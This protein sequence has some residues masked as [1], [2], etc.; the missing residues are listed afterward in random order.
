MIS[1]FLSS[2]LFAQSE[3]TTLIPTRAT[4]YK[5]DTIPYITLKTAYVFSP[6][7]FKSKREQRRYTKL[8]RDIKKVYPYA[9][10]AGE[11]I[12]M[13]SAIIDT[14]QDKKKQ[15]EYL[16]IAEEALKEEFKED[17]K[18]MTFKQGRLLIKLIDRETGSSS[19]ELIK[20]LRGGFQAFLWQQ[21]AKLFGNDLKVKYDPEGED[22]LIESIVIQIENGLL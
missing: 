1:L 9:K 20:Y 21:F 7:V 11:R 6:L 15:K 14:I 16:E 13:Y 8:V 19:Y 17:V 5:G 3:E 2:L 10:I 22:R 18:K 12:L 4:I